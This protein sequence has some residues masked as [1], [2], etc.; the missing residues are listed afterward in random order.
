MNKIP[1]SVA[2]ALLAT[3]LPL[4]ATGAAQAADGEIIRRGFCTNGADWKIKVKPDDNR[5]E[6]EAEIDTNRIGE[7]WTWV[8]RHNGSPSARGT[9]RTGGRSGSFSVERKMVDMTGVDTFRFRAVRN[10]ATCT[11]QVSL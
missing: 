7:T 1:T 5:I 4:V 11:A 10:G 3:T 8:F 2:I 6:V 9:S